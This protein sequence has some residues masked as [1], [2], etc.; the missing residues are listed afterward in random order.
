MVGIF[1]YECGLKFL[2]SASSKKKAYQILFDTFADEQSKQRYSSAK[3]W[4]TKLYSE[5]RGAPRCYEI[6]KIKHNTL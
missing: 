6:M 5:N 1:K 3:D 4:Y 2:A